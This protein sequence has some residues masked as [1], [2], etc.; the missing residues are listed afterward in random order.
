M[1]NSTPQRDISPVPPACR[2]TWPTTRTS[3]G[4][5]GRK[6][7]RPS[8]APSS[9][10]CFDSR[11]APRAPMFTTAPGSCSVSRMKRDQSSSRTVMRSSR[12][13]GTV[14]SSSRRRSH[15][16]G[17]MGVG[18]T[19]FTPARVRSWRPSG[20][21]PRSMA[22][23]AVDRLR[24]SARRPRAR[25]STREGSGRQ[26]TTRLGVL[27]SAARTASSGVRT[28]VRSNPR[29]HRLVFPSSGS[30]SAGETIRTLARRCSLEG[31]EVG[32]PLEQAEA[33]VDLGTGEA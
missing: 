15:T 5:P 30:G 6:K 3:T 13:A 19:A 10:G 11:S 25:A 9:K 17:S 26:T 21:N 29:R 24:G 18:S 20:P 31:L 8:F 16:K 23:I 4:S 12:R 14:S 28:Q 33:L 2:E 22:T 27:A 7:V 32:E 1:R